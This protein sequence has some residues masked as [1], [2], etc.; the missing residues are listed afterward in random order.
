MQE[1]RIWL[2]MSGGL[3]GTLPIDPFADPISRFPAK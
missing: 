3:S 2:R 1:E